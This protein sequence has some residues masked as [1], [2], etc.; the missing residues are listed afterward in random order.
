MVD[1]V[2]RAGRSASWYGLAAILA[3]TMPVSAQW[4]QWGG[5]NRDFKIAS[6]GTCEAWPDSSPKKVWDRELGAGYSAIVVDGNTLYT[7][8]RTD[9]KEHVIALAADDGKTVWEY[10][11]ESKPKLA[12]YVNTSWGKG[13]NATPLV[14]NKRVVTIGFT[15]MLLCLDKKNGNVVWQ[16]DLIKEFGAAVLD[17]GHAAS[18]IGYRGKVIVFPGGER[19]GAMAFMLDDGSVAWK[20]SGFQPSYGSPVIVQIDGADQLVTAVSGEIVALDPQSGKLLWK[21]DHKNEY[22]T[23]LMT[24]VLT[25]DGVFI[26]N[27]KGGGRSWTLSGSGSDAT[28]KEKWFSRKIQIAHSNAI[29]VDGYIYGSTGE[30]VPF[31]T[32][33]DIETGRILWKNRDFGRSNLV[34]ICADR[35]ILL[36]QDGQLAYV[37]LS[38][39]GLKTHTQMQLFN[40]K[41]WTVPTVVGTRL[42]ARDLKRIL[43][44][45]L[46]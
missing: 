1:G 13:P 22:N 34:H 2:R 15:G 44:L 43:A 11:Y 23:N 12:E 9:D 17:Y 35:F 45:D 46:R 3:L 26:S 6:R 28:A 40:G 20:A 39:Q 5:R 31:L 27:F 4:P 29:N 37:G 41:S 10:A 16:H 38:P 21:R 33:I 36:D 30:T 25:S 19:Q 7:M 14:R 18:P 32:A 8:Y 24:P 42:Y